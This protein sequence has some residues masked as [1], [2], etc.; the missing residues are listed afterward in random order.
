MTT[1]STGMNGMRPVAVLAG[2]LLLGFSAQAATTPA[3]SKPPHP[4]AASAGH[5]ICVA[6]KG[7]VARAAYVPAAGGGQCA[8]LLS[9]DTILTPRAWNRT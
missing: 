2:V 4:M 7:L 6:R 3:P 5:G 9:T 1:R 8:Q